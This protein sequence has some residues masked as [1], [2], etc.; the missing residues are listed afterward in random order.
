LGKGVWQTAP[1]GAGCFGSTSTNVG[2]MVKIS[3]S[4]EL[5]LHITNIPYL[6]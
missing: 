5:F 3:K 1:V 2:A 4:I 6:D